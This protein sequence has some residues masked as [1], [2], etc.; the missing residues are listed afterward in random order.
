[1]EWIELT[2]PQQLQEVIEVSK[3]QPVFIFKHS[4]TCSVSRMALDRLERQWKPQE[5]VPATAYFLD[6]LR[7]R[8]LSNQLAEVFQVRHESPQVLVI[9]NGRAVY[10][11]SHYGITHAAL[12]A[13]LIKS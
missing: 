3:T 2:D 6:L 5:N 1:M 11:E 7:H 13:A 10:H 12:Q 8:A 9:K 4:T